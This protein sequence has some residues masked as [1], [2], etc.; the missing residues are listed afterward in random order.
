MI[1]VALKMLW[2]ER[3]KAVN[4]CLSI[5]AS[6]CVSLV[7]M[8]FFVNPY[9]S[10]VT[11]EDIFFFT[12]NFIKLLLALGIL[13]VCACLIGY[14]CNYHA[15]VHSREL[16][17]V[18]LAG[19]NPKEVLQYQL[20]QI[21]AIMLVSCVLATLLSIIILPGT[22][23]LIYQ[24]LGIKDSVFYFSGQLLI[25]E[26]YIVMLV[27]CLVIFL[28][29]R[30]SI[31]T[32]VVDLLKSQ[33]VVGYHR[34]NHVF[35]I[36]DG[37]FVLAYLVG[38]YTMFTGDEFSPSFMISSCIGAVGAYGMCY[39]VIPHLFK[40]WLDKY[41]VS[42]KTSVVLGDVSLFMQQ[43]KNLI[44]FIMA[45]IIIMPTSVLA[46]AGDPI[47]HIS[48]HLAM[49]LINLLLS[50]S[51]VNRFMVD[52]FE[53]KTHYLNLYKIGLTKKEVKKVSLQVT[54]CFYV[55]LWILTSI[56][57][58][59]IFLTFLISS[60]FEISLAIIVL[61][62]CLLPYLLSHLVVVVVKGRKE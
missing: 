49:V 28:E 62:E 8:Q 34:S 58:L 17:L 33:N 4:L 7:F 11:L 40:H 3:N 42:G 13:I 46:T 29:I 5:T 37:V 23:Y 54:N 31:A 57:L 35:R 51:L 14:A 16:G 15:R 26:S 24:Y 41:Q 12:G 36:P 45:S 44:I 59:S 48:M 30:Y 53:K 2:I 39:H 47:A 32:S 10:Y 61:L 55:V 43:A 19:Y 20:I 60:E 18:K 22:L 25:Q 21:M 38:I 6:L 9:L 52:E 56:Y 1:K 50:A 27:L